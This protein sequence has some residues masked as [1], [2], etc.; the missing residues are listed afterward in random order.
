MPG[1]RY[2]HVKNEFHTF[3][4]N[5]LNRGPQTKEEQGYLDPIQSSPS[6]THWLPM[7][8]LRY[9]MTNWADLRLA[10]TKTLRRPNFLDYSP[11]FYMD[12]ESI[13]RGNTDL[14]VETSQN[15]DAQVSVYSNSLGLF[16]VGGFYKEIDNLIY[17]VTKRIRQ[18][19]SLQNLPDPLFLRYN[20]YTDLK[21]FELTEPVNNEPTAYVRGLELEWQ[22]HFWYLPKPLNGLILNANVAFI[23]TE[24]RY[25]QYV[26]T[27]GSPPFYRDK[28]DSLI[29]REE[30]LQNQP[31][32]VGNVSLGYDKGGFSARLSYYYQG[33]TLNSISRIFPIEDKYKAELSRWDL[34]VRQNITRNLALFVDLNNFTNDKDELYYNITDYLQYRQNYGWQSS[35]GIRYI[36]R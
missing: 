17:K 11:I 9:K 28:K 21:G 10:Y 8:H 18:G 36:F 19:D 24:T 14:K 1:I 22:T 12:Q 30:R 31:N 6:N 7:V 5:S 13:S 27:R 2:E 35:L 16:T 3:F 20:P 23:D 32:T 4:V 25:P 34:K 33:N 26:E 29:Y 15:L